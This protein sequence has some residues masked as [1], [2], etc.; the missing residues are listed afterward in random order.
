MGRQHVRHAAHAEG[1]HV[2]QCRTLHPQCACLPAQ[3]LTNYP[4]LLQASEE[5]IRSRASLPMR[6]PCSPVTQRAGSRSTPM[7]IFARDSKCTSNVCSPT[8][9]SDCR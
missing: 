5:I 4:F 6:L 3:R 9:C 7:Q 1:L 8:R 2:Q